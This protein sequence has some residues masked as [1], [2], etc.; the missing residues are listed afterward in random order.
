MHMHEKRELWAVFERTV[1][2]AF[3]APVIALDLEQRSEPRT[4]A[5]SSNISDNSSLSSFLPG[6]RTL[7]AFDK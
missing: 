2:P 3:P 6:F 4:V 1:S 7:D 5:Y